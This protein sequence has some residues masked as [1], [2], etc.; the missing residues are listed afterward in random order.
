[1]S[2]TSVVNNLPA[3]KLSLWLANTRRLTVGFIILV[4][5]LIFWDLDKALSG[6]APS[7]VELLAPGRE[8][9]VVLSESAPSFK[10][11]FQLERRSHVRFELTLR[12]EALPPIF[13]ALYKFN[14][15]VTRDS[16]HSV[17][18]Q[19]TNHSFGSDR[20]RTE[21][22]LLP[23]GRYKLAFSLAKDARGAY[24]VRR[25]SLKIV[26]SDVI[27]APAN[28]ALAGFARA[29]PALR[30]SPDTIDLI[31]YRNEI[32]AMF[33]SRDSEISTRLIPAVA[34]AAK[35][36]ELSLH[37]AKVAHESESPA[38]TPRSSEIW[39]AYSDLLQEPKEA[40]ARAPYFKSADWLAKYSVPQIIL[41][42]PHVRGQRLNWPYAIEQISESFNVPPTQIAVLFLDGCDYTVVIYSSPSIV[43][44]GLIC[45]GRIQV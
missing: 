27:P 16:A 17:T 45:R 28:P 21:I 9:S 34:Q 4:P 31:D 22:Y 8:L 11:M 41:L 5:L 18:Q 12:D 43:T 39:K 37:G 2:A 24:W 20:L 42:M 25:L 29:L 36:Q 23:P 40:G 44:Y 1:M 35:L 33:S 32:P 3:T 7:T 30:L 14:T 15:V 6:S 10:Y 26:I 13:E 38:T 19:R